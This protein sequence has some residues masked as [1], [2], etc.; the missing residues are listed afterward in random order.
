MIPRLTPEQEEL[1]ERVRVLVRRQI[2]PRAA[3]Y[4]R[5]GAFPKENF[6]DLREEGLLGLLIPQEYG[7]MGGD[8]LTY[9]LVVEEIAR[10]CGSTALIFAMHCGATRAVAVGGTQEQRERY[11]P[12]VAKRGKLFAWA[13]SEPGTGGNILRPQLSARV[14]GD[15]FVLNGTKAFCTGAGHVD[16]YLINAQAES[17]EQFSKSQHFF[18]LEPTLPG[19]SF[20]T[21]WDS[22]G[23]RANCSND[24]ILAN[25]PVPMQMCVGGP[26][27]GIDILTKAVSPLILGLA[28]TSLGVGGAAYGFAR[29][30]VSKR[31]LQTTGKTLAGFQAVRFMVADMAM[32]EHT[33]RLVLHDSAVIADSDIFEAFPLMNMAKYT[34]NKNAIDMAATAMQACG[35][36]GYQRKFPL[37][38]YFRDS[39]AG[40]VMGAN[41]EALR[42]M[43]GKSAL[44]MDPRQ[45]D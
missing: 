4:D 23:M 36:Q 39:R 21:A 8:M 18:V 5:S 37:E 16:Y 9:V 24:L 14:Q 19:L 22:L 27:A 11:L 1:R 12:A 44:G 2:G 15:G 38:R 20:R 45:Q 10:G 25:V 35:G 31:L 34:C 28:A 17:P 30:H 6:D 33:A 7:G 32:M 13:F 26:G 40:A 42:D 43:I 3:E 41:L 29:E